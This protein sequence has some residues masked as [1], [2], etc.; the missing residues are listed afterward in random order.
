MVFR[1]ADKAVSI[2]ALCVAGIIDNPK[3]TRLELLA[4]Q[5][6]ADLSVSRSHEIAA[7]PGPQYCREFKPH[8]WLVV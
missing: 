4:H 6:A 5:N 3:M 8:L 7:Y 1:T 2:A